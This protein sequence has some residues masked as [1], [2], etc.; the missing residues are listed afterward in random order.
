MLVFCQGSY[1]ERKD[2]TLE[3]VKRLHEFVD[4]IIIIAPDFPPD[5]FKEWSKVELHT[6]P[7]GDNFPEYRN[8]YLK[9]C[10]LGDWVCVADPDEWYGPEVCRDLRQLTSEADEKEIGLLLVNSHDIEIQLDGK[11][12]KRISN[13]FKNLIFKYQPEVHYEG[14]GEAKNVHETLIFP[15]G[16]KQATLPRKYYYE[17]IKTWVEI[18]ERGARNV[19]IGGGGNNVGYKNPM[20]VELRQITDRLGLKTWP[21]VREYIRR[22]NVDSELKE[23]ILKHKDDCGWD[24][25]NESRD[26]FLWYQLVHASEFEGVESQPKEPSL[27]SPPEVMAWVEKCYLE[28]L[29]RQADTSG[30]TAYTNAILAGKIK[31]GDLPN[32]LKSGDEYKQKFGADLEGERVSL[33]VPVNVDVRVGEDSFV[34]ALM[35]SK[36]FWEKIKP[37]IDVASFIEACLNDKESFYKSFYKEIN[38]GNLTLEGFMELVKKWTQKK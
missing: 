12:D 23:V 27:G 15:P 2:Q 16:T 31:R 17:H 33:A 34:R 24:W 9:R 26:W 10:I 28:I 8:E 29:G 20:F 19:W 37:R 18:K 13:F 6:I 30:K 22:G 5:F 36:T 35:K 38:E 3:C 25:E 14:V 11:V 4:R 1:F 21:D 7:W 32:I